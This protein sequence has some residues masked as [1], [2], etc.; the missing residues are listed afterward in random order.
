LCSKGDEPSG[1]ARRQIANDLGVEILRLNKWITA[2]RDTE[3]C[4][5]RGSGGWAAWA[6]EPYSQ[7]GEDILKSQPALREPKAKGS[8]SSK[9]TNGPF[10]PHI[11]ARS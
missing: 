6:R 1:L 9:N 10:L 2:Y 4:V 8:G 11:C 5:A 3:V 7:E